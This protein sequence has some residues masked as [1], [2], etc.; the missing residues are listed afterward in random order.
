[1]EINNKNV[2]DILDQAI[3]ALNNC[4]RP[5]FHTCEHGKKREGLW[6][7]KNQ[8]LCKNCIEDN[9][10]EL[11]K[12]FSPIELKSEGFTIVHNQYTIRV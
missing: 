7:Y 10:K 12:Q 2:Q 5:V 11:D 4:S 9:F 3:D 8:W 1:M 6:L